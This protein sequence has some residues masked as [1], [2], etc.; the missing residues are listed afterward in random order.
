MCKDNE[1][2]IK[3]E[4]IEELLNDMEQAFRDRG[5]YVPE[6]VQEVIDELREDRIERS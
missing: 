2:Q 4:A 3:Y 1:I 6:D 5:I